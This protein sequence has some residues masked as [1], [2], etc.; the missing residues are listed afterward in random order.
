MHLEGLSHRF[1]IIGTIIAICL[2]AVAIVEIYHLNELVSNT[3]KTTASLDNLL[4]KTDNL[5]GEMQKSTASMTLLVNK[6]DQLIKTQN[7]TASNISQQTILKQYGDG[8]PFHVGISYCNY[9]QNDNEI[10]YSPTIFDKNGNATPLKFMLIRFFEY[11]TLP[12]NNGTSYTGS[13]A[14]LEYD[15]NP[16]LID[17]SGGGNQLYKLSLLNALNQTKNSNDAYLFIRSQ[18]YFAPYSEV[19]GNLLT[20]YTYDGTGQQMIELMKG[21]TGNWKLYPNNNSVCK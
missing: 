14:T 17:P 3:Q 6:T 1:T 15:Q 21:N 2:F 8:V 10:A 16:E 4:N 7:N 13:N 11:Y 12:T 9:E 19:T 20:K 5:L 18:Y